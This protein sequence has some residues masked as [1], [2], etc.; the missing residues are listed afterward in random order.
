[1]PSTEVS[2][3]RSRVIT[4]VA[5]PLILSA[6]LSIWLIVSFTEDQLASQSRHY[7]QGI[8]DQLATL[9]ADYLI[10]N[11]ILSLNVVLNELLARNNFHFAA[12]YDPD[13]N[14]LAQSGRHINSN[15]SYT[16]NINFESST[17]GHV[18]IELDSS[19]S[20]KKLRVVFATSLIL[21]GFIF[22]ITLGIIWFYG[23]RL[24]NWLYERSTR[25]RTD[26]IK[27]VRDEPTQTEPPTDN[28]STLAIKIKP[29]RLVP[30]AAIG[31]ACSLYNGQLETLSDEEWLLT[32]DK[33]DQ[34]FRSIRC[35]LLIREI[36]KLQPGNLYFKGGIDS[37]SADDLPMLRKQ[38]SYLASVSDENLLVSKRVNRQLQEHYSE[39]GIA[40]Q[41]FHSSLIADDEVF[42][43]ENPDAL[44]ERQAMQLGSSI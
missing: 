22:F 32:F 16:R 27:E 17:L 12:I 2:Y 26:A 13:N 9:S 24:Q 43:V 10:S 41:Q 1:M 31:K 37:A 35:G 40:A 21:H 23:D 20:E 38:S 34:L 3:N 44:L 18:L 36:V 42:Y 5:A 4:A 33:A 30:L 8:A 28:R 11:D 39:T 7:G 6:L 25:V 19:R 29:A 14:L 15:H